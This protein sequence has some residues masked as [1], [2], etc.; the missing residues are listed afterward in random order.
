MVKSQQQLTLRHLPKSRTNAVVPERRSGFCHK[1][2]KNMWVEP[3]KEMYLFYMH[4]LCTCLSHTSDWV[5]ARSETS[6]SP[7]RD[8]HHLVL[9]DKLDL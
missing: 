8:P 5:F 3:C 2:W 7:Q 9:K 4:L 6:K 1:H